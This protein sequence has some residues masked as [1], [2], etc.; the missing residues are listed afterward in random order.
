MLRVLT[1]LGL[2]AAVWLPLLNVATNRLVS[3]QAV[4]LWAVLQDSVGS[5]GVLGVSMPLVIILV[6][7]VMWGGVLL[8]RPSRGVSVIVVALACGSALSLLTLA[9]AYASQV[10]Q[11]QSALARTSLGSAFWLLT[12]V[13]WLTVMDTLQRLQAG[14][15]ARLA[16]LI[17]IVLALA[18]L[19]ASGVCDQLSLMKEYANH[20]DS[21]AASILRHLQ[22]VGLTLLPTLCLGLPLG[23]GVNRSS[24][25]QQ[26]L[27]PLLNVVQTI[28]SIA[29]FGLLMV[30]LAWLAGAW[31]RLATWGVSGIGLAPAV[32]ALTLYSLL[33]VVRGTQAGLAQ[34]PVGVLDAARGM[35]MS[36]LQIFWRAQLPLAAPVI[37]ASVRTATIQ[38]VGL[39]AVAALI[40]AGGLGV[41]M[42]D[43]LFSSAQDLVLLGVLPIMGLAL[44]VD[45]VFRV[46][47]EL[48]R[49][50]LETAPT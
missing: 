8:A 46:L 6:F 4:S 43:G 37:L 20:A 5:A 40:G 42:F 49:P 2:G 21:F 25:W 27:L 13:S 28:P 35:G 48:V 36:T 24:K 14:L 32:V 29:L 17:G 18:W 16:V 22:I 33:P 38:A 23:W 31:P 34:V 41:I 11:T 15:L 3:G 30:P 12:L 9:G 1:A 45:M 10:A 19:L 39:A 26:R 50:N 47:T 7:G 44:L